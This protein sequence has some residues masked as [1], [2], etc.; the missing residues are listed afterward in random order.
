[1]ADGRVMFRDI[2]PYEAP[3][4]LDDLHSPVSGQ[5]E[6]PITVHWGQ[7]RVFELADPDRWRAAYRAIVR[8]GTPAEQERLLNAALLRELWPE[9]VLPTRCQRLWEQ[10]FPEL[11]AEA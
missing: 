5:L 9:L 4:S 6:I 7:R 11:A 8:E 10:R 2:V 1:M 3:E